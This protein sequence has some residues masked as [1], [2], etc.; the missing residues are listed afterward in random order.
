MQS[1]SD[2]NNTIKQIVDIMTY[3]TTPEMYDLEQSDQRQF[4]YMMTKQFAEFSESHV[5]I[6]N[7][8]LD[9]RNRK[10]NVN[11]LI[12]TIDT[13]IKIKTNQVNPDVAYEQ[14][15]EEQASKYIYPQFGGKEEFMKVIQSDLSD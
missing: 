6:F 15:K 4:E 14:F 2:L 12:Q 7:L 11:K 9:K 8:L 10:E 13:I 3:M 1:L 5:H